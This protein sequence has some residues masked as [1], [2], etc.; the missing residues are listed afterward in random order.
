MP[1]VAAISSTLA[2]RR[3]F[4]EPKLTQQ[5]IFPVLTHAGTIVENAF[6]DAF[7]HQQLV[8]GVGETMRFIANALE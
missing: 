6:A 7:L 2:C 5:K 4:T 8:I 1:S 3:R